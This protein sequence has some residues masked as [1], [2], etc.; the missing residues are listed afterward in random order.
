MPA[1][2]C[3]LNEP[4]YG[5]RRAAQAYRAVCA[6]QPG[7]IACWCTWRSGCSIARRD[8]DWFGINR[9]AAMQYMFASYALMG[10]V[11]SCCIDPSLLRSKPHM[12]CPT[13]PLLK[14]KRLVYGLAV[15]FGMNRSATGF[16]VQS[17]LALW[18]YQTFHIS[19]A[20]AAAI[21]FWS[22]VCSAISYLVAV[23]IAERIGLINTM[24]FTHL[25]SNVLLMLVPFRPIWMWRLVCCW[26]AARSRNLDVPTRSSY[27]MA[28]VRPEERPARPA[29]PRCPSPSPGRR[30]R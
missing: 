28:V 23:P 4:C 10:A 15:L 22:S 24:V 19:I 25:P 3:H 27:V 2:S 16:L 1:S 18:L 6:L 20:A 8:A 5:N 29:S 17:L 21:L 11:T 9:D 7:R 13:A 26:R 12:K 14:S 30:G